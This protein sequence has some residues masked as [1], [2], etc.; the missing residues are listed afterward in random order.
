MCALLLKASKQSQQQATEFTDLGRV[1]CIQAAELFGDIACSDIEGA[2]VPHKRV[3]KRGLNLV[4][5]HTHRDVLVSA[6]KAC[7]RCRATVAVLP[8]CWWWIHI[9]A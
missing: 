7:R 4:Q 9:Q 3:E 8:L 6:K 5:C 2:L 1:I